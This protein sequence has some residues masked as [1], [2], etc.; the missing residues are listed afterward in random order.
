LDAP[1]RWQD[2][3]TGELPA[4]VHAFFKVPGSP[5]LTHAQFG[6]VKDYAIY[7]I[8]APMWDANPAHDDESRKHLEELRQQAEQCKDEKQFKLWLHKCLEVCIDPF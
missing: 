6:M 4:A 1:L 8:N 7:Y 5:P 2:E 3:Q